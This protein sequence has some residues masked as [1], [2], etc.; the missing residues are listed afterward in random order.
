MYLYTVDGRLIQIFSNN[1]HCPSMHTQTIIEHFAGSVPTASTEVTETKVQKYTKMIKEWEDNKE[2]LETFRFKFKNIEQSLSIVTGNIQQLQKIKKTLTDTIETT[3]KIGNSTGPGTGTEVQNQITGDLSPQEKQQLATINSENKAGA[4]KLQAETSRL[5]DT[6]MKAAQDAIDAHTQQL[7]EQQKNLN[8]NIA[9]INKIRGN[10][11]PL[12]DE[13]V[14]LQ[15]EKSE[16]EKTEKTEKTVK[17]AKQVVGSEDEITRRQFIEKMEVLNFLEQQRGT[18]EEIVNTT[19]KVAK[20]I[21]P[22]FL[23]ALKEYQETI[24][25]TKSLLISLSK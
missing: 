22:E 12:Y 24:D 4:E 1:T 16:T 11:I 3:S 10:A 19:K 20:E 17:K 8:D 13:M 15:K 23:S 7:G 18:L 14:E 6:V 5:K 9:E 25:S 2:W 21:Y